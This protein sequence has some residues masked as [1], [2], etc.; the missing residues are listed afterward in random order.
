[1]I[2]LFKVYVG[3]GFAKVFTLDT[4]SLYHPNMHDLCFLI[5]GLFECMD[6]LAK[7]VDFVRYVLYSLHVVGRCV[8]F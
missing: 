8:G 2:F 6:Q 7:L 5:F 4:Q 3:L 1:V